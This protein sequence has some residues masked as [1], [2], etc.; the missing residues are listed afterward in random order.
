MNTADN[1]NKI[2]MSLDVGS[3]FFTKFGDFNILVCIIRSIC[4]VLVDCIII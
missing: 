2:D 4:F 3:S 1:K